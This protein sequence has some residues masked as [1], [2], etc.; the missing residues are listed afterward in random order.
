MGIAFFIFGGK[1]SVLYSSVSAG[2]I[3]YT[4]CFSA[5]G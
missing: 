3:E 2:A 5:D 1:I 4:D